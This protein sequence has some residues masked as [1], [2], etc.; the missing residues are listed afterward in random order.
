M[1]E[2][3]A[4]TANILRQNAIYKDLREEYSPDVANALTSKN[5][6]RQGINVPP[7]GCEHWHTINKA[8]TD[9]K[10]DLEQERAIAESQ[11]KE[12]ADGMLQVAAS[13][14][15]VYPAAA[16]PVQAEEI[17]SDFDDEDGDTADEDAENDERPS[18]ADIYG[19][20]NDEDN[21]EAALDDV[22]KAQE[23]G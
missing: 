2:K 13:S 5:L 6:Q 1:E 9:Q 14:H 18:L 7:E 19:Y 15:P 11:A 8:A 17:D 20:E 12:V 23:Q 10:L 4:G 22:L 3:P 16:Q 21:Q